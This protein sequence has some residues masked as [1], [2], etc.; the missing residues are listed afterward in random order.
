[1]ISGAESTG[2]SGTMI[3]ESAGLRV[4]EISRAFLV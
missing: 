4:I 1:M 3:P 2:L